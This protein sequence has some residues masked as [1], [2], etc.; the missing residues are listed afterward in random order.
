MN[1]RDLSPNVMARNKPLYEGHAVAAAAVSSA[2]AAEALELIGGK[3]L[4]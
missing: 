2:I 1:F 3:T 4:I